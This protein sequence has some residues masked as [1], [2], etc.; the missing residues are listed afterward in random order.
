[1]VFILIETS[2]ST[3]S[4]SFIFFLLV[5]K[6]RKSLHFGSVKIHQHCLYWK[7]FCANTYRKKFSNSLLL[8]SYISWSVNCKSWDSK[9][10]HIFLTCL[11]TKVRFIF[12]DFKYFPLRKVQLQLSSTF[13]AFFHL[14]CKFFK[15][16]F[17]LLFQ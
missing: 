15:R 10:H 6:L 11:E 7:V 16:L 4:Y 5:C 17:W 3:N 8:F 14:V 2:L 12:E 1:M 13:L 9:S